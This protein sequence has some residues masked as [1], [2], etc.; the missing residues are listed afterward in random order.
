VSDPVRRR[1]HVEGHGADGERGAAA[2]V[3]RAAARRP[4]RGGMQ[5]R[6]REHGAREHARR[7]ASP[8]AFRRVVPIVGDRFQ[9]ERAE[10]GAVEPVM[11]S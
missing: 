2:A 11:L 9:E 7:A 1:C 3:Q 6:L 4:R 8:T 5:G 10:G